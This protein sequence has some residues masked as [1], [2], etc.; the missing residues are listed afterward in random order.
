M[1]KIKCLQ[2]VN[3]LSGKQSIPKEVIEKIR[4]EL[5]IIKKWSDE[6]DEVT[7]E[8]FNTDDFGYGYIVIL[9]GDETEEELKALGLTEGLEN[10]IPECVESYYFNNEKWTKVIV[11]YNDSFAMSFWLKN[12]RL[13]EDYED[14]GRE[15]FSSG[16]SKL[17]EPF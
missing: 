14:K 17:E 2:D 3:E 1:L 4:S 10:V 6:M 12:S 15:C 13:F 16:E 8:E 5:L 9:E 7:I 11:I